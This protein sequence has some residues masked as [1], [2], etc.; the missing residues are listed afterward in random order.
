MRSRAMRSRSVRRP[1]SAAAWVAIASEERAA[2]SAMRDIAGYDKQ[3]VATLFSSGDAPNELRGGEMERRTFLKAGAA[4]AFAVTSS[5]KAAGNGARPEAPAMARGMTLLTMR[6]ANGYTL[7]VKTA[8]GVLDVKKAARALKSNAPTTMDALIAGGDGGLGELVQQAKS[9]ALYVDEAKIAFGPCVTNPEKIICVGL[10]YA[11]HAREVGQPI[12]KLPILFNKYN[13]ALN[14]HQGMVRVSSIPAQ[15]FD[16]EAELVVVIGRRARNVSEAEALSYVLGYA[17][18]N[19]FTARD[20]Q[21]RSSQWM[22]GKTCDGSGLLGPYLVTADLVGDPT[23]LKI[24]C[25]VTGEV[26]Q[27]SN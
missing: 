5:A 26:R 19:D 3:R 24:E 2:M 1:L 4:G 14:A 16:Y 21:S 27:S 15:N 17:V 12:P 23:N 25:A 10:N 22:I 9:G 20:L 8:K 11:R 13:N 7:G 6:D 18:G